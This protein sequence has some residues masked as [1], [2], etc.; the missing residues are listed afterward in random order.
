[1]IDP[2]VQR[3]VAAAESVEALPIVVSRAME[4]I[5]SSRSGAREV[6]NVIGLDPALAGRILRLVNSPYY[7]TMSRPVVG[8]TEAVLRL[9][10]QAVQSALLTAATASVMNPS[11][12]RYGLQRRQFWNHSVATAV[13][14]RAVA[15]L[16]RFA[17]AE[18]A[19]VAGLLHDVGKVGLD[20]QLATAMTNVRTIVHEQGLAYHEAEQIELGFDHGHVGQLVAA[21]WGLS[22]VTTA[23]IGAHHVTDGEPDLL[24][25]AVS[26]GD[27]MAWAM[28]FAGAGDE[29]PRAI[30]PTALARLGLSPASVE[31]LIRDTVPL[32]QQSLGVLATEPAPPTARR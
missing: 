23:A 11:L 13:S 3:A 16:V 30:E 31:N 25:S 20:R 6:A 18:E 7:R 27:A 12:S 26:V 32:V 2:N 10:Y 29:R 19:Y 14:A 21:R 28:G 5:Y 1:M 17:G 22:A 24:V 9:G 4:A 8:L 15:N